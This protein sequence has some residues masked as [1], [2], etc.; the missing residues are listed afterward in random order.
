MF[1]S[2]RGDQRIGA[3][4]VCGGDVVL[5]EITGIGEHLSGRGPG[6]GDRLIEQVA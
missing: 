6:V 4:R 1:E 2:T 3:R 5:A